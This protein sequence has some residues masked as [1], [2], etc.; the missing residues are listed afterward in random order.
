MKLFQNR[1]EA[2][3]IKAWVRLYRADSTFLYMQPAPEKLGSLDTVM[4]QV[5]GSI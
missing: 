5:A 3:V 2:P 4:E 1:C